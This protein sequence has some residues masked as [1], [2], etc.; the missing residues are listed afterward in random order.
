MMDGVI[1]DLDKGT[2]EAEMDEKTAQRDYN[3]LMNDSQKKRAENS[4]SITNKE[5]DKAE[6]ETALE[7]TKQNHRDAEEDLRL[8]KGVI[9]DLHRSCDFLLQN[10]DV[11][12]EARAA[13][14]DSLK[15]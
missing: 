11:R 8:N 6:L 3:T 4:E 12:K 15:N 13:E 5:A 7:T 9:N 14:S 2:Q 1:N 10:Y